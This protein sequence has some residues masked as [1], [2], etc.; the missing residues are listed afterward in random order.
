M[1]LSAKYRCRLLAVIVLAVPLLATAATTPAPAQPGRTRKPVQPSPGPFAGNRHLLVN[2]APVVFDIAPPVRLT[3]LSGKWLG[4]EVW[5]SYDAAQQSLVRDRRSQSR[6]P[7]GHLR[8]GTEGT[9]SQAAAISFTRQSHGPGRE[10]SQ[11]Q[12]HRRQAIHRTQQSAT[13]AHSSGQD[14]QAGRVSAHQSGAGVGGEVSAARSRC[15]FPTP[16][17]PGGLLTAKFKACTR[18]WITASPPAPPFPPP[19]QGSFCWRGLCTSKEI[20]WYSITGRDCS[21]FTSTF[22][23]SR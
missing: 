12:G 19:M 20:A 9:T 10:I 13:G 4:H 6:N 3:H 11:H 21:R 7:S 17:A 15:P 14:G 16:S 2:G 22:R 8:S 18:G 5:F 23:R 1:P